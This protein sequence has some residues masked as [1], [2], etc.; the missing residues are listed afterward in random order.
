M[1]RTLRQG[2]E[3]LAIGTLV[4]S[5]ASCRKPPTGAGDVSGTEAATP[6]ARGSGAPANMMVFLLMGQSNMAG[7]PQ[8]EERDEAVNPRVVV[9]AY[10]DCP[11]LGR[12]HDAWYPA[13]PPLHNCYGGVGPGDY[14]GKALADA[15]PNAT[16][17][18]VPLAI[19]GAEIDM[20]RKGVVSR[21]REEFRIPPDNH[22]QGAYEWAIERARTAQRSGTIRGIL[23][24]QGESDTGNPE[25]VGKVK[26]LVADL[27]ADLGLV[28]APFVAGELLYRGCCD[29][30]NVLVAELPHAIEN[31][32][33]VS[34]RGLEHLDTA[35]FDLASQRELGG[36]YGAAMIELLRA[37]PSQ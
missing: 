34:A 13:K 11:R 24:H 19:N 20:F 31:A 22:W 4:L 29:S 10:E 36:R 28:R 26:G 25:W 5:M 16:I 12:V 37:Q 9:L 2:R 8:P 6:P 14:F 7:A 21:R 18:L 1:R 30:H 35:H 32:R 15:Y 3:L 23:F 17:G 27:R 33:V